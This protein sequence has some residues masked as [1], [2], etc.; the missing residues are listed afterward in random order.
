[1]TGTPAAEHSLPPIADRQTWQAKVDE[2]RVKEKAHTRAYSVL[3][4]AVDR[5]VAN[6][7][8]GILVSYLRDGDQV[9]ETYWTTGRG[10]EL[11]ARRT[12]CWM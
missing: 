3:Q 6:R 10:N 8:F 1:M 4:D 7:H 2:L 9:Y 11:M 12:D 5:L